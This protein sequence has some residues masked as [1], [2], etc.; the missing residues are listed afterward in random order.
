MSIHLEKL[1]AF[2]STVVRSGALLSILIGALVAAGSSLISDLWFPSKKVPALAS[3]I[4]QVEAAL[5]EISRLS[6]SLG[7]LKKDLEATAKEKERIETEYKKATELKALT[8]AQLAAV[9]SALTHRSIFEV[10]KDNLIS[11]FLGVLSSLVASIVW[12]WARQKRNPDPI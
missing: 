7:G 10:I 3:Q 11:F 9:H 1:E 2:L 12:F 5:N 4:A 6:D 8:E